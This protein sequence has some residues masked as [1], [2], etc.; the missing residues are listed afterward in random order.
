[1]TWSDLPT[2]P[3]PKVLRQFSAAWLVCF[4]ALGARQYF[5]RG[6]NQAGLTFGATAVVIGLLGLAK[7]A[8]VRW[9]FVSWMVIAFPIGWAIS[10]ITLALMFYG[11]LTPIAFLFRLQGRDLLSRKPAPERNTYWTLKPTPQDIHSYFR[12]Y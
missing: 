10:Q 11:L 5:G 2:N 12:Q 8:A 6:H 7:P 4:L 3:S 9:I 1:M